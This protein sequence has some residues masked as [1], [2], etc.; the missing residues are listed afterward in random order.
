MAF[1]DSRI[2]SISNNNNNLSSNISDCHKHNNDNDFRD[3]ESICCYEKDYTTNN[4]LISNSNQNIVK[5]YRVVISFFDILG[6]DNL[7]FD[8]NFV[9]STS[10]PNYK[11]LSIIQKKSY[12]NL[13]WIVKS[14]T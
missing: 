12:I 10:P 1:S 9:W 5:K 14:N 13:V 2:F 8:W 3:C 4:S 11:I 7:I 6:F